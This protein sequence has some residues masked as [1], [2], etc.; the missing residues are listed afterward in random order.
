[1]GLE[2]E[3]WEKHVITSEKCV[4]YETT[5][6]RANTVIFRRVRK[7]A[8]SD[9]YLSHVYLSVRPSVCLQETTRLPTTRIF[10][11]FDI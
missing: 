2:H 1:M 7:I 11:K 10:M 8:K 3:A 9:Y 6:I 4:R 5:R